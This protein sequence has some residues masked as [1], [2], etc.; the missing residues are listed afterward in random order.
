MALFFLS[1]NH[2][3]AHPKHLSSR[4]ASSSFL[5]G[6]L[7]ANLVTTNPVPG[8]VRERSL[9]TNLTT[10][11]VVLQK[12]LLFATK[13][14][15]K[16]RQI[17]LFRWRTRYSR[18]VQ[19]RTRIQTADSKSIGQVHASLFSPSLLD[20]MLRHHSE[21]VGDTNDSNPLVLPASTNVEEFRSLLWALYAK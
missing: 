17:V 9:T 7:S 16:K 10:M 19:V 6:R 2:L 20:D 5:M 21:E 8:S 11:P 14:I 4:C 12:D 13:N 15:I 18:R 1:T 3:L